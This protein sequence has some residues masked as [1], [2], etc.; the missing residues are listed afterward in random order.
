MTVIFYTSQFYVLT[1]MQKSLKVDEAT[2]S[3]ILLIALA[4]GSPFFLLC[5]WLS[6]KIGRK[7]IIAT[8]LA[9]ACVTYFPLF[10]G[11]GIALNPALIAASERS[12]VVVKVVK[13]ECSSQLN[14]VAPQKPRSACDAIRRVL[15][16]A[17]VQYS[18]DYVN[19]S[20]STMVSIGTK[21]ISL[22]AD[23]RMSSFEHIRSVLANELME[24][25]YPATASESAMRKP[26]AIAILTVMVIYVAMAYGPLAA[27]LV[28][29]NCS[30][31][32][33]G[34]FCSSSLNS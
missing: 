23:E 16:D 6:D 26:L 11:L 32:K 9:L 4:L 13:H 1:F 21:S 30:P 27:A 8:G 22:S 19:Y 25:G 24:A 29:S 7:P 34:H 2:A 5:G 14:P 10:H 18:L 33:F 20:G 3:V 31:L 17:G 15:T 12:P 28:E